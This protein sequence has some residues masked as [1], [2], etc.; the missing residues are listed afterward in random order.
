M[1]GSNRRMATDLQGDSEGEG[2]KGNGEDSTLSREQQS[3]VCISMYTPSPALQQ[4]KSLIHSY[5]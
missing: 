4:A 5:M 3:S 2:G 1:A